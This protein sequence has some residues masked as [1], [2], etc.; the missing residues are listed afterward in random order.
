M[1]DLIEAIEIVLALA[2]KQATTID[3]IE[4]CDTVE[5]FAVNQLGDD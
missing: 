3:E 5:D 1:M 2:R 4:A